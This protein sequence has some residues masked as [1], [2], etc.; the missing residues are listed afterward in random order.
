MTPE[1]IETAPPI[2]DTSPLLLFC[3][4]QGGWHSGVWFYGKWLAYID[5]S[6]ILH[7][8]HWMMAPVDPEDVDLRKVA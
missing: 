1:P 6:I 8:T 7:P 2:T 5:S 4:E 3:P